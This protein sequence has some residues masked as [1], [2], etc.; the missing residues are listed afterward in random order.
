[1]RKEVEEKPEKEEIE[2][3]AEESGDET[4]PETEEEEEYASQVENETQVCCT[5]ALK[6]R[7]LIFRRPHLPKETFCGI[8]IGNH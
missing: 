8:E 1:V 2:E 7:Q 6:D 3:K 5:F 4:Q